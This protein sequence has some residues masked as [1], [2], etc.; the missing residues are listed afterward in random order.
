VLWA[1]QVA[2]TPAA[3]A[4]GGYQVYVANQGNGTVSVVN[5]TTGAVTAT[6]PVG[7][8]P[9]RI[10]I[11]PDGSRLYTPNVFDGTVSVVDTSTN[12]IVHSIAVGALPTAVFVDPTGLRIHVLVAGD[13]VVKT[14]NAL[15]YAVEATAA[16]A[17]A[18]TG[19]LSPDGGRLYISNQY[20]NAIF[21]I[22]T[23]TTT[24][25]DVIA[26]LPPEPGQI[27]VAPNGGRLYVSTHEGLTV[28]DPATHAIIAT[29]PEITNGSPALT[30]DGS[31]IYATTTGYG[32]VK[33]FDTLTNTVVGTISIGG[34]A[35]HAIVTPDGARVYVSENQGHR[36]RH[37]HRR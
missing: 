2:F 35:P 29:I 21:V 17:N 25:V 19:C 7:Q 28:I 24:V 9:Y 37:R 10:A 3:V 5:A 32:A 8:V 36:L 27:A 12:T 23:S 20:G 34:D 16:V 14:I 15:T 22:D 33:V 30:P 31:R 6:F 18:G 1:V 26:G 4:Q 13:S 11:S